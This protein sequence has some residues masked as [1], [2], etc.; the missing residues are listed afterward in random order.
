MPTKPGKYI[1]TA[2]VRG[3]DFFAFPKTFTFTIVADEA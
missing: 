1:V 3:G 2:T